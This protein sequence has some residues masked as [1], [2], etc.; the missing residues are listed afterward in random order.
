MLSVKPCSALA[1]VRQC[2]SH[3]SIATSVS[4]SA[5]VPIS[6]SV[7]TYLCTC[8]CTCRCTSLILSATGTDFLFLS[9]TFASKVGSG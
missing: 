6:T 8:L 7:S 3:Q 2:E 9:L 1:K 5:P 4:T